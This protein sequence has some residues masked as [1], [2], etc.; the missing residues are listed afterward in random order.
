M[1]KTER[2]GFI[3]NNLYIESFVNLNESEKIR[4]H[5]QMINAAPAPEKYMKIKLTSNKLLRQNQGIDLM[6]IKQY[7]GLT[8]KMFLEL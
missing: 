2:E 1:T 8:F 7:N 5:L 4:R 3:I 6:S